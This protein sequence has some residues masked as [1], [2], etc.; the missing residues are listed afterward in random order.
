MRGSSTQNPCACNGILFP[1][2]TDVVQTPK[3]K[4]EVGKN[5]G[6]I[7]RGRYAVRREEVTFT[8]RFLKGYLRLPSQFR[9]L[10]N[11]VK[12]IVR[13]SE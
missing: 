11:G 6:K 1:A 3:G 9:K 4:K 7:S 8:F 2:P 13:T 10:G 12:G 5:T